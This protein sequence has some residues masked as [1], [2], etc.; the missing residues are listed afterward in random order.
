ML[1]QEGKHGGRE[2][3]DNRSIIL[4]NRVKNFDQD[5]DSALAVIC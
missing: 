1:L 4:M 3:D 5:S 2:V